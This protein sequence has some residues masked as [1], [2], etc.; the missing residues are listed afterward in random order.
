MGNLVLGAGV[1]R[2][3][4]VVGPRSPARGDIDLSVGGGFGI[5]R[6]DEQARLRGH[7]A[8]VDAAVLAEVAEQADELVEL[9]GT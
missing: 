4:S 1:D 6:F 7:D 9:R 8:E 2:V 3:I 5:S